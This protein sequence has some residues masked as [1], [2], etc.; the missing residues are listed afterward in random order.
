MMGPA[1]VAEVVAELR[2]GRAV[3]IPTDTVYGLA[4]DP[5]NARAVEAL[6]ELKGRAETNPIPV[7]VPDVATA[8]RCAGDWPAAADALARAFWPGPLT[9]VV[10]K[11]EWVPPAIVAGGDSVG[12]RQ[13]DH[14]AALE[15]LRLFGGPLACTSANLSGEPPVSRPADLP[16]EWG[17]RVRVLDAGGLPERA[18][19]T[20]VDVR[21]AGGARILREGPVSA[22]Q[23]REYAGRGD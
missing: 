15:V 14:P 3:V 21:G 13:P 8:K 20:V 7:L 10:D 9:I 19:S 6:F 11:A 23:V 22:E 12:L 2:A 17:E 16:G 4:A 18:P 1:S 5:Q